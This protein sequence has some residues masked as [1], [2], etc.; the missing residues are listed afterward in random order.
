[1][2]CVGKNG[3]NMATKVKPIAQAIRMLTGKRRNAS[4]NAPAATSSS[5]ELVPDASTADVLRRP[6]P[7]VASLPAI[8]VSPANWW[9]RSARGRYAAHARL[10][11]G[12][13][14]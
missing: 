10:V 1:M 8:K 4:A 3:P 6:A 9:T 13:Y 12:P 5:M 14:V 11:R 7:V 2:R